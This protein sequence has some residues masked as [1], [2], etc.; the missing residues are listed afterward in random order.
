M[1]KTKL[2]FNKLVY[3]G[4]SILDLNKSLMYDF[5]YNYIKIKYADKAKLLFTDTDSLAYEIKTKDIYKDI[6]PDIE[7]QFD[8][9]DYTT[10]H[11]SE[12]K[13]RLNSKVLGMFKDEAGGQQIVEFVGLRAKLYSYKM[14]D[15]SV[16]KKF[17]SVTKNVT[18]RRIQFDDYREC[19]FSRKAQ[20]RQMIV[21]RSHCHQIYTEEMNEIALSSD[22]D[23]RVIVADGIH[24]LAYGHTNLK[25]IVIKKM[26]YNE[27]PNVLVDG[28]VLPNKP[29]SNLEIIDAI[30]RLSLYGFRGV[31]LR[32]TLPERQN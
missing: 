2:Y 14:L 11:S 31:F 25:K 13:T 3:L 20:H 7:K 16:D 5:H 32:D 10:N 21:I 28:I 30:K 19:L 29:L 27:I 23:K 22:D 24:T 1:K 26:S 12:I 4:M 17:N 9:S 15:G 18:K 6:N 8:T